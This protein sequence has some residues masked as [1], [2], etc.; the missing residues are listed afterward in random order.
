[1]E[2]FEGLLARRSGRVYNGSPVPR[3]ALNSSLEAGLLAPSS[4]NRKN[5]AFITVSG[6]ETML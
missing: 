6:R 3:E 4:R 1:M 5:A 2:L